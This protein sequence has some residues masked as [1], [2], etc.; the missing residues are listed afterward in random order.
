MR[1]ATGRTKASLCVLR[2]RARRGATRKTK[3]TKN[4]ILKATRR[5]KEKDI[6]NILLDDPT[7]R[8]DDENSPA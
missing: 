8:A 7:I 6:G 4:E 1:R 2:G 5:K 3:S